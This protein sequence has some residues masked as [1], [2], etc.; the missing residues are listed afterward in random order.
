M[1]PILKTESKNFMLPDLQ[2]SVN[3][4]LQPSRIS[5]SCHISRQ[6]AW[7]DAQ[8]C[9]LI[10]C[11]G[12]V[13]GVQPIQQPI[14]RWYSPRTSKAQNPKQGNRTAICRCN[15][16]RKVLTLYHSNYYKVDLNSNSNSYPI[17][18]S[19]YKASLFVS[20]LASSALIPL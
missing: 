8:S 15:K 10:L 6:L 18:F 17:K 14:Q 7:E 16:G 4:V 2:E 5:S 9:F 19:L 11:M 12:S 20:S 1:D 3:I 13:W